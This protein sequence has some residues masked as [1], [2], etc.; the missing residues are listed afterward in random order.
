MY[1]SVVPWFFLSKGNPVNIPEPERGYLYGNI[2]EP[3]DVGAGPEKSSLF[4]LTVP[5]CALESVYPEIG[6]HWAGKAS[7]LSGCSVSPR[8][9]LK[10]WARELFAPLVVL[11]TAS[12]L[13]GEQPLVDR[14][15]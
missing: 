3:R 9:S 5:T 11:I 10:I 15:M 12:G 6:L 4:F 1:D 13:Q 2:S 8:R 7:H 14:I